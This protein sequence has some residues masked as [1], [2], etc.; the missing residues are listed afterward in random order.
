MLE[1]FISLR[2]KRRLSNTWK[3][4]NKNFDKRIVEMSNFIEFKNYTFCKTDIMF[5]F[6]AANGSIIVLVFF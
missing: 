2:I 6:Y 5:E 4:E 3:T 1:F